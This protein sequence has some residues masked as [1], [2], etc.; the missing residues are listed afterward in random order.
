LIQQDDTQGVSK[1]PYLGSIPGLGWLFGSTSRS[2]G[3]TELIV[4]ITP[5][6]VTSNSEAREVTDEYQRQFKLIR[7]PR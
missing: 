5:R 3:R 2:K 4:L 7:P 6:V 1:V